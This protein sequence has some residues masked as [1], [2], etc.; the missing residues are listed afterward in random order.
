MRENDIDK[1][2]RNL[3]DILKRFKCVFL[4]GFR[5]FF[6]FFGYYRRGKNVLEVLF[7]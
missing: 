6:F 2:K 5:S 4:K 3:V 1:G 7:L